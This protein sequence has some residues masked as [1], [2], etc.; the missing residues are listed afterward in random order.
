MVKFM[1]NTHRL[2]VLVA[3]CMALAVVQAS[4]QTSSTLPLGAMATVNG[5]V[6]PVKR[7][8]QL[9]QVNGSQG[10]QD[11]AQLRTA[12]KAEL[13]ARELLL[14]EAQRRGPKGAVSRIRQ[15]QKQ[16]SRRPVKAC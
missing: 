2:S 5:V 14:Q 11:T 3:G 1:T 8:D 12:L 13:I 10:R 15:T 9:V 16:H 7:L 6:L 4:A